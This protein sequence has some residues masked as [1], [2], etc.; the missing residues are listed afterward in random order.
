MY[1]EPGSR[2]F[3]AEDERWMIRGDIARVEKIDSFALFPDAN[4]RLPD[5]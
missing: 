1:P 5:T 4:P 3:T 2:V